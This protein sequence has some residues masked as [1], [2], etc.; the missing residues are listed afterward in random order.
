[1]KTCS[2]SK[3]SRQAASS[4]PHL[5]ENQNLLNPPFFIQTHAPPHLIAHNNVN[6]IVDG[7]G[8]NPFEITEDLSSTENIYSLIE[9]ATAQPLPGGATAPLRSI[10]V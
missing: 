4:K 3:K 1:M 9:G 2:C 7:G 10:T 6:P 5:S 8:D